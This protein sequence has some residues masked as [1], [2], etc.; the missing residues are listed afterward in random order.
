M[1]VGIQ[2][3]PAITGSSAIVDV[4]TKK[5]WDA[6]SKR[7]DWINFG[8]EKRWAS[9]KNRF[10]S[11]MVDCRILFLAVGT[12]NDFQNFPVGKTIVGIDISPIMLEKAVARA[13]KYQGEIELKEMDVRELTF[14]DETFDQVF[15]S[16][17]F[18]SVPDPVDGLIELK[19]VL[20][21]GGDLR[22]FEHTG[23]KYFPFRQMLNLCNPLAELRGPSINRDTIANVQ[24]AG[25]NIKQ[26][27]NIYLDILKTIY[28]VK[29]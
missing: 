12:G 9:W 19:R 2:T 26:V 5:I 20:K 18:C 28:A 1:P 27:F 7:Y 3:K 25:F 24:A 11:H 13:N 17:T 15:T 22:M 21:P 23:S 10:F 8:S 14:P 6:N 29:P 4:T 16:C